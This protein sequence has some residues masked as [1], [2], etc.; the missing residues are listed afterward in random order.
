MKHLKE[1]RVL[2]KKKSTTLNPEPQKVALRPSSVFLVFILGG[3]ISS[4]R[5]QIRTIPVRPFTVMYKGLLII[6][7]GRYAKK[8]WTRCLPPKESLPR[9][10]DALPDS[11]SRC[12]AGIGALFFFDACE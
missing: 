6:F 11:V 10:P 1:I 8:N 2:K 9:G 5:V 12:A 7:N 4:T 3:H